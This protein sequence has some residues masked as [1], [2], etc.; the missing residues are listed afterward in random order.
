MPDFRTTA[1]AHAAI[2]AGLFAAYLLLPWL[3]LLVFGQD[4]TPGAAFMARRASVAFLGLAAMLMLARNA[5]PGEGRQ[6][7]A[8]G[9]IVVYLGLALV[10]AQ[11][12]LRGVAGLLTWVTVLLELALAASLVPHLGAR[13]RRRDDA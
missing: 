2:L 10:G 6:A 4:W 1:Q 5:P 12:A 8:I 3:P 7:I 11:A 9:C 13:D